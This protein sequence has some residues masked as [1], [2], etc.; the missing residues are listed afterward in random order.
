MIAAA[1]AAS[2]L[3]VDFREVGPIWYDNV[4]LEYPFNRT[5][6]GP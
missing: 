3:T 2:V 5:S 4:E 6:P 1:T